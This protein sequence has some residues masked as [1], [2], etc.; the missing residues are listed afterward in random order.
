VD[1]RRRKERRSSRKEQEWVNK[2]V[3]LDNVAVVKVEECDGRA[4]L[5]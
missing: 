3:G 1:R 4:I 2:A 5:A